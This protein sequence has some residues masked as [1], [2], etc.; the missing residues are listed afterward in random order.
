[1][2]T[3]L[4]VGHDHLGEGAADAVCVERRPAHQHR[5]EHAAQR[6]DVR[7]HAVPT[8]GRHLDRR[9]GIHI[10]GGET[11]RVEVAAATAKFRQWAALGFG[12]DSILGRKPGYFYLF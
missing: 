10:S 2:P 12:G 3:D 9:T 5:V 4:D 8:A 6:P 7:L 11:G 1:M